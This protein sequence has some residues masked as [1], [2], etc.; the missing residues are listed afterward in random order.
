[1]NRRGPRGGGLL[2]ALMVVGLVAI[3]VSAFLDD[4]IGEEGMFLIAT[5]IA[6]AT[7]GAVLLRHPNEHGG[8]LK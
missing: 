4:G 3:V 7:L 6:V 8:R 1:M 5:S 2:V